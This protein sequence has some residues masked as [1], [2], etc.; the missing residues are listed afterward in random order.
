[1][2]IEVAVYLT[3]DPSNMIV[4]YVGT[5]KD[6]ERRFYEHV[7]NSGFDGYFLFNWYESR[8]RAG[9]VERH[10]IKIFRKQL[11]NE[12]NHPIRG[13]ITLAGFKKLIMPLSDKNYERII[14]YIPIGKNIGRIFHG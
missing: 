12:N 4:R 7:G 3:F 9:I 1:M 11:L 5:S 2:E 13:G 8:E 6:P 14:E 10:L